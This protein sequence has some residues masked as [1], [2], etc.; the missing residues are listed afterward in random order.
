MLDTG[1]YSAA[2]VILRFGCAAAAD[3]AHVACARRAEAMPAARVHSASAAAPICA[4]ASCRSL[5]CL[6]Q[7]QQTTRLLVPLVP[8]SCLP[9]ALV[10]LLES[11]GLLSPSEAQRDVDLVSSLSEDQLQSV[12]HAINDTA[13]PALQ[14]LLNVGWLERREGGMG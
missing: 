5:A 10:L 13:V 7:H 4:L 3:P 6:Q 8:L 11:S 2:G 12:A 1:H 9:A 14:D